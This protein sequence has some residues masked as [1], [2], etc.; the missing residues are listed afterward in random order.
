[1]LI[2]R[3][4]L[5]AM[6]VGAAW[7][8]QV[9]YNAWPGPWILA[10]SAVLPPVL[11]FLSL[12]SMLGLQIRLEGPGRVVRGTEA[13]YSVRF[14]NER[15]LPVHAVNLYLELCNHYTENVTQESYRLHN[16]A[17]ARIALP[18][19]TDE[20]GVISCR[21]VRCELHDPLGLFVIRRSFDAG[22]SCAV[23]PEAQEAQVNLDAALDAVRVLKPKY[24]G[25]FSEE[26]D[27][28]D[29]RPGDLP[30]SI[31]WKLSSKT[32]R[33]IVREALTVENCDVFLVLEQPGA[34]DEGL[35][36]LRW[37]SAE[38]LRREEPHFIIADSIYPAGNESEAE[39]ALISLLSGPMRQPCTFDP[40][41]ARCV[42][43]VRGSEVC[44]E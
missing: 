19:P 23:L 7:L 15:L 10:C 34:H 3:L 35:A 38:L 17:S 30:N 36:V 28:R 40:R 31:H 18:L 33:L 6:L 1:M 27:L 8:M 39:A 13:E 16:L 22:L 5:W 9:Y 29:Y 42:F 32:D 11:F 20:C 24:G 44:V 14:T 26:H 25:G 37:L 21:I 41:T 4:F 2:I 43:R 12:P